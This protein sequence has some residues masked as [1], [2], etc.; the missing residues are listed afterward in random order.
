MKRMLLAVT[1]ALAALLMAGPGW[2][3][4]RGDGSKTRWR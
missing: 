3:A 4:D 1:A 2:G